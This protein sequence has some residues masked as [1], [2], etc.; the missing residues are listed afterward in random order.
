MSI[1]S[2]V[3]EQDLINL[4]KFA[5]QQKNQR[6]LEIIIWILKQTHVIKIAESLSPITKK[7]SEVKE[8]TQKLREIVKESN[9]PRLVIRNTHN[10]LPI[11]NEQIHPCVIYDTFLENTINNKKNRIGFFNIEERDIGE[12]IWNAFPVEKTGGI[13]PKFIENVL[14]WA[15][16]IEKVLTGASNIPMKKLNEKDREKRSKYHFSKVNQGNKTFN[17]LNA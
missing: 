17:I 10:A 5:E 11:K 12:I 14:D 9:T 13:K 3:A 1:Y 8:S 7:L 6:A 2:D 15:P 4:H 16:G